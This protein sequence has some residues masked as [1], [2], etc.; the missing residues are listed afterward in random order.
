LINQKGNLLFYASDM[1]LVALFQVLVDDII[2]IN[3]DT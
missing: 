2:V 1:V 3:G